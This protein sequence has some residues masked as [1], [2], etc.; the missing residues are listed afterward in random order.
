MT[1]GM[2]P[3]ARYME[4]ARISVGQLVALT[5]M[6]VKLVDAVVKGNY[7]PARRSANGWLPHSASR[8][9]TFPGGTRFRLNTSAA[10]ARN[11]GGGPDR[12]ARFQTRRNDRDAG[13]SR[14]SNTFPR[15]PVLR[16]ASCPLLVQ[17]RIVS[18]SGRAECVTRLGISSSF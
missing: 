8:R 11:P 16:S 14:F 10:T 6:D 5:G 18:G 15:W 1:T 17:L 9:R 12:H 13:L 2:K 7:T 4:E 3:L